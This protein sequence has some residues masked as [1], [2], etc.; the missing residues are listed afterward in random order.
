MGYAVRG[1]ES[2]LLRNPGHNE[3]DL[4]TNPKMGYEQTGQAGKL[5]NVT[6]E[7]PAY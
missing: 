6:Y 7:P 5:I 3:A 1:S 2:N 4:R